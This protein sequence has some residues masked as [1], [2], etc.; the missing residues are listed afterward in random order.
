MQG[1][2]VPSSPQ[3]DSTCHNA[4]KPVYHSY[5]ACAPEPVLC[6]KR[7]HRN[8]KPAYLNRRVA[9]THRNESN[10]RKPMRSTNKGPAQ[11]NLKK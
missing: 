7:S 11:P 1:T 3:E 5:C 10:W 6:N 9:T 8:E 4:A 2:Y